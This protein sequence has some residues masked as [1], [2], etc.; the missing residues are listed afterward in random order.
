METE[1]KGYVIA[2][3][4]YGDG[5]I[6][7]ALHIQ[8]DDELWLFEDDKKAAEA[9]E[10]DGIPLIYGMD[11]VEDGIYLDTAENRATIRQA[12][13]S[14]PEYIQSKPATLEQQSIL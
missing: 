4:G 1:R 12:L 10:Q 5:Y 7:D 3:C 6:P 11:G 2:I 9:A 8:R 13:D 14:Y